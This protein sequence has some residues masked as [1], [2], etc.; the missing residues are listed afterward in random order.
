MGVGN[1]ESVARNFLRVGGVGTGSFSGG[2]HN[3]PMPLTKQA[4]K[5]RGRARRSRDQLKR[6]R[7][8]QEETVQLQQAAPESEGTLDDFF[9]W[10]AETL[11]VPTGPL[12]GKP[13]L[14]EDF[15]SD[16]LR[17][18]LAPGIRECGLSIARKN[19]KSGVVAALCLGYL[20][21]P[22]RTKRWRGIAISLTGFL[23]GELRTA[24][25]Q[26]AEASDLSD[27]ISTKAFP[28]PGIIKGLDGT[29]LT[30]LA[31]D[32]ATGHAVGADLA[33]IDEAGLLE[34]NRRELWNAV[35][36]SISARDGRFMCISI[37]GHGPMFSE[38]ADRRDKPTVHFT[39]Y[40]APDG[41]D[42]DDPDAW[43]AA[44]PGLGTI[45]SE[46]Y[47]R[48][49]AARAIQTPADARSFR[50]YELNLP[51]DPTA[52]MLVEAADWQRCEVDVLPKA[53]GPM[54]LAFDLSGG[55][56]MSSAFAYWPETGLAK[57]IRR[58]S[59]RTVLEGA[60]R[61]R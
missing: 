20:V 51:Q 17:D 34:E 58:I 55:Y 54:V 42:L 46:S 61:V 29:E 23:A 12:Q 27:Y 39:E 57:F 59:I 47:M 40:A 30:L 37:R 18:A 44:N 8:R 15:Q 21:G 19:G 9:A 3:P 45:K 50:A 22:L 25:V 7:D 26:T 48:D 14:I 60:R 53:S 13:F 33:I 35:F 10:S 28:P 16:W 11:K 24:I 6:E 1:P 4:E 36:S 31:S 49:A 52:S 41:C 56:S 43:R 32:K 2:V 38:L 5:Y